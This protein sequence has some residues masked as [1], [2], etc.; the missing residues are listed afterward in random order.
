MKI[1]VIF[2]LLITSSVNA[3]VYK[4]TDKKGNV[5]F[6]DRPVDQDNATE[7]NLNIESGAGI[8][9]SAGNNKERDRMANELEEDRK[10]RQEKRKKNR[11]AQK[12]KQERCVRLK[13][14]LHRYQ[15]ANSIYKLNAKGDRVYYSKEDR[16]AK[17]KKLNKSIAKACR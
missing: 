14:Q 12:K 17:E 7:L 13:D 6:G 2:F 9:N 3:G 11:E 4:W 1:S 5:H 8:T 10:A 16:A 15:R